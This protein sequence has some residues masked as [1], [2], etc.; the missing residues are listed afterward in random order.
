M[1]DTTSTQK[2]ILDLYNDLSESK[3]AILRV[4]FSEEHGLAV[5][6]FYSKLNCIQSSF[7]PNEQKWL[8]NYFNVKAEDVFFPK[9]D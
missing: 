2:T 4:Q 1:N 3:K 9:H 7:K 5:S 6:T 8:C